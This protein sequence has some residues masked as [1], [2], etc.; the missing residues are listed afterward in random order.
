MDKSHIP[1]DGVVA[2]RGSIDGRPVFLYAFDFT[3]YGG[4]LSET[5]SEKIQKVMDMAYDY[6]VPCIGLND[7]G[8]ARI[9]EGVNSLAGYG[10]I[11]HRNV[12]SSGVIP[13]L[14][15]ILGPSAGGAVYS[16]ALTDFIYM[17]R[18][19]SYMFITGP[20]VVKQVLQEDVTN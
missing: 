9:Q 7:S 13:Q 15:L 10:D 18:N 16:P 19:S 6:G 4:S 20:L 3:T 1:G 5:N 17:V 11:F 2:G 12:K 8:G 14:S